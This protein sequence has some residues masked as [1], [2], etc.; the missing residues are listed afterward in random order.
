V[1]EALYVSLAF[2]ETVPGF[3]TEHGREQVP[4]IGFEERGPKVLVY[5]FAIEVFLRNQN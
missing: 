2:Y 4:E 1:K 3:K 5:P